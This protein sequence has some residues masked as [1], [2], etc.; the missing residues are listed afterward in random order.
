VLHVV[1]ASGSCTWAAYVD[2]VVVVA[3]VVA[4]PDHADIVDQRNTCL[5]P[6]NWV[7]RKEF[8]VAG[9]AQLSKT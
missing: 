6:G 4:M 9:E 8:V 1:L 7:A 2:T 3:V 5:E